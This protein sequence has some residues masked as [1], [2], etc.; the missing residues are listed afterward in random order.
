MIVF[1]RYDSI[2]DDDSLRVEDQYGRTYSNPLNRTGIT[3]NDDP[4]VQTWLR[5]EYS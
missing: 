3:D 1:G 4:G 2:D 5:F